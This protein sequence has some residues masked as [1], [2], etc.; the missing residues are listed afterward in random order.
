MKKRIKT[1]DF[2]INNSIFF[3]IAIVVIIT[4]IHRLEFFAAAPLDVLKR[5]A[6]YVPMALGMGFV[7]MLGGVDL[8]AGRVMGLASL[9]AASFLWGNDSAY[10]HLDM[11]PLLPIPVVLAIVLLLGMVIGCFNGFFIAKLK[12]HPFIVT[13][14]TQLILYGTMLNV[15][16][17]S[18]T[19]KSGNISNIIP[20]YKE[21][22][23]NTVNFGNWDIPNYVWY[24]IV[25]VILVWLIW[26][27]TSF[28]KKIRLYGENHKAAESLNI[29]PILIII[30]A[31]AIAGALYGINGFV[32][33]ARV[34][35]PGATAGASAELD[36][37][38]ACLIGGVSLCGGKGKVGGIVLGV[39]L[40]QLVAVCFQWL[41][42]SS[43]L[44]YIIKGFI[45]LWAAAV[46]A[47]KN[48]RGRG[49]SD[50]KW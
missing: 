40:L 10:S 28:G 41:S 8:S 37:I 6:A 50:W 14:S 2:F 9:I 21:L 3:F 16:S 4:G 48:Y 47:R 17:V 33:A 38:A 11:F 18:P 35:G 19:G 29:D 1:S 5:T 23:T 26:N 22:I 25:I 34:G 15:L 32:E 39:V 7:M 45:I 44:V 27:H 42:L 46:D 13:L 31:F 43:N 20:A 24:S 12:L 49:I 30:G 36:A